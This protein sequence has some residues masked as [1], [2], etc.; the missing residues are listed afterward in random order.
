MLDPTALTKREGG[1]DPPGGDGR[2]DLPAG[3]MRRYVWTYDEAGSRPTRGARRHLHA[4]SRGRCD[5]EEAVGVRRRTSSASTST[6][7]LSLVPAGRSGHRARRGEDPRHLRPAARA[8]QRARRSS[9]RTRPSSGCP[10]WTRPRTARRRHRPPEPRR[11]RRR[12][13]APPRLTHALLPRRATSPSPT[14][15]ATADVRTWW[16][17][18]GDPDAG[19]EQRE[20]IA[21]FFRLK[22][23]ADPD[24]VWDPEKDPGLDERIR[25][26]VHGQYQNWLVAGRPDA[27]RARTSTCRSTSGPIDRA[28]PRPGRLR[29][30]RSR[31]SSTRWRPT[32]S[33]TRSSGSTTCSAASSAA[34]AWP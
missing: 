26:G 33:P 27:G 6:C 31:S 13:P 25:V 21:E 16:G 22:G 24:P 17:T 14:I 32:S 4:A 15:R 8:P 20:R 23:E 29:R 11:G 2:K 5:L 30:G 28:R 7:G 9:T 18:R 10:A 1:F 34:R 3:P 12:R 19:E